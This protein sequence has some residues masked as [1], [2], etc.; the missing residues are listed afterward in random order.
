MVI[1]THRLLTSDFFDDWL[2]R[3]FGAR[4]LSV[5]DDLKV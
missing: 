5:A 1:A 4:A 3:W 2:V